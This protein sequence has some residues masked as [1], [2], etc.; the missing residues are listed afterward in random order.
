VFFLAVA[1]LTPVIGL[2]IG[3]GN[4]RVSNAKAVQRLE[5]GI[6]Q[7]GEPLTL[8]ELAA[9]YPA[10]PEEENA[11]VPLLQVWEK[12][13][14]TLWQAFRRGERVLPTPSMP[15]LPPDLPFVGGRAPRLS[16]TTPLPQASREAAEA[17][18]AEQAEHLAAV[19]LA[20]RRPRCRFPVKITD[21]YFALL[22]YLARIKREAQNFRIVEALAVERGDVDSAISALEDIVRTG[23]A[24]TEGPMLMDQLVRLA[25]LTMVLDDSQRLLSQQPL[26]SVQLDRLEQFFRQCEAAGAL[27]SSL[28][29]ERVLALNAF[30]MPFKSLEQLGGTPGEDSP[31]MSERAEQVSRGFWVTTGLA[32]ADRRLLLETMEEAI[33]LSEKDS[34]AALDQY[35]KLFVRVALEVPRFPPKM[36]CAMLLPALSRLE[37]R[38]GRF[39]ACRR[40][41]L[42]AVTVQRFRLGHHG[43]LP[44]NLGSLMP[45]FLQQVPADPFDG[46]PLR[47][48]PRQSGFVVYSV[49][50]DRQDDGGKERPTKGGSSTNYDE[51]FTVER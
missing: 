15:D 19:R 28:I 10:I 47:F 33:D 32:V 43:N 39:E 48:R 13:D 3:Y 17:Y 5:A 29:T 12:E 9:R 42:V 22:P 21:G 44:N 1:A 4:F 35:D 31:S 41:A 6:Q 23:N 16:R 11:A 18:L 27:R 14:P 45:N 20:L 50:L 7:K 36:Y 40:S 37:N 2:I 38:F 49:G 46:Q 51:T 30:D 26:S 34:P 8:A 25:C 24:L